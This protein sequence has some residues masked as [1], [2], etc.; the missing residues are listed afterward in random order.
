MKSEYAWRAGKIFYREFV[1]WYIILLLAHK[2]ERQRH[3]QKEATIYESYSISEEFKIGRKF[4]KGEWI[5]PKLFLETLE[6]VTL[7]LRYYDQQNGLTYNN[8]NMAN[9]YN[10]DSK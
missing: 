10:N 1:S 9:I 2:V 4:R 6:D 5:S 3:L 7:N 8:N